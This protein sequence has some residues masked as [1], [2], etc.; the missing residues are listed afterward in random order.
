MNWPWLCPSTKVLSNGSCQYSN[1]PKLCK[2]LHLPTSLESACLQSTS[3]NMKCFVFKRKNAPK[4][5]LGARGAMWAS[6]ESPEGRSLDWYFHSRRDTEL[7]SDNWVTRVPQW[8]KYPSYLPLFWVFFP[9]LKV[10]KAR[11]T[12]HAH[13]MHVWNKCWKFTGWSINSKLD[14][15]FVDMCA[16]SVKVYLT[17]GCWS[18][19]C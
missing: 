15:A 8:P 18:Q 12:A 19:G 11:S 14:C 1:C 3:C 4:G 16:P 9:F 5:S 7:T 17:A 6:R 2:Q 10:V 13:T